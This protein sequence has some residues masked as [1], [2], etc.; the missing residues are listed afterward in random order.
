MCAYT[1]NFIQCSGKE[2]AFGFKDHYSAEENTLKIFVCV[3][4]YICIYLP[5]YL[6]TYIHTYIK[7][8]GKDRDRTSMS[9]S[10]EVEL[11]H[12]RLERSVQTQA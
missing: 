1:Y 10:E 7:S 3:Y 6:P 11:H 12:F 2:N 5:T 4:I 8:R 9:H